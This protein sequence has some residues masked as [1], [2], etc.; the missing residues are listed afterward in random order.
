[1]TVIVIEI[2]FFNVIVIEIIFF[3]VIVI[4]IILCNWTQPWSRASDLCVFQTLCPTSRNEIRYM[5][6]SRLRLLSTENTLPLHLAAS[7]WHSTLANTTHRPTFVAMHMSAS[8]L[9]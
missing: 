2:I 6:T 9:E 7:C 1:M 8:S 3:N 4:D 5:P